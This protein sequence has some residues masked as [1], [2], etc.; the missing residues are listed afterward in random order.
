[1]RSADGSTICTTVPR[2]APCRSRDRHLDQLAGER[3]ADQHDPS[4]GATGQRG[5][6]RNQPLGAHGHDFT[7]F[8]L[9]DHPRSVR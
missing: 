5:T 1:M 2:S 4:V 7:A 3:V 9:L 6:A 8:T